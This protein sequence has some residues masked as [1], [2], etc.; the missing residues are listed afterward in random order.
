MNSLTIIL[1]SAFLFF[2]WP[3][4]IF[5][6]AG[7]L[8]IAITRPVDGSAKPGDILSLTGQN[9]NLAP[10]S[11]SFDEK[12]F[13][14]LVEDPAFLIKTA[15]GSPVARTGIVNVNISTLGGPIKA[16][17]YI[18]SSPLKGHGQKA[19][20]LGGYMLGVALQDFDEKNG[21]KENF[22][23]Q[24]IAKGQIKTEIGIGP[25]SPTLIKASGGLLGTLKQISQALMFN[26]KTSRNA[27]KIIRYVIA[28][29]VAVIVIFI[30]FNTFGKNINKGIEAIGRNPLAK[31]SIQSMIV[32]NVILIAIVSI[33]GIV[34]SL[35]ILSL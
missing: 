28:G 17:D 14:V 20:N 4:E 33:G 15:T 35:A 10:A 7:N 8:D 25:A 30:N 27:E 34:L 6:Q 5:S 2:S 13:G 21:T 23:N 19:D 9:A 1:F 26:I 3:Q 24:A 16:G 29:L 12:M 18:T 22:E 32:I 31:V 11:V